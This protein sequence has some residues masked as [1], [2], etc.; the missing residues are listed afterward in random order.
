MRLAA[1]TRMFSKKT[2]VVAW[3]IIV[4]IGRMVRPLPLTSRMSTRKTERPAVRDFASARGVVRARSS[5]RSECSAR[6]V[7][8]F[9]PSTT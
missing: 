4:R 8:I 6:E 7:Q 1:G 5:I 9:W 3:F 2:S